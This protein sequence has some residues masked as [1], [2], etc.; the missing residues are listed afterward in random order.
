LLPAKAKELGYA[1][2]CY[3][4]QMQCNDDPKNPMY[5]YTK[6]TTTV[7]ELKPIVT[8]VTTTTT[9]KTVTPTPVV[10]PECSPD[11]LCIREDDAKVKGLVACNGK[12]TLCGYDK[13]QTPLYCFG[14]PAET[15]TTTTTKTPQPP[16]YPVSRPVLPT[17]AA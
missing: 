1:T 12:K 2:Y 8:T 4:K 7:P 17:A 15:T 6:P 5:C 10:Y 14:K 11:C 16:R 3:G 9:T 13:D